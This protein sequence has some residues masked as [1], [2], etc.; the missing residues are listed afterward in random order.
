[1]NDNTELI[2][3]IFLKKTIFEKK[4]LN[5]LSEKDRFE[6]ID[7]LS[8]SLVYDTLKEHLNFIYIKNISD[9]TLQHIPNIIFKVLANE[10]ISYATELL[11]LSRVEALEYLQTAN[12]VKYIHT[13]A[14]SYYLYCRN[15]IYEK[16]ADTFI[17]LLALLN[18]KSERVIFVNEVINSKLMANKTVLRIN[19]FNQLY[20]KIKFA[21]N[22]KNTEISSIQMK[23]TDSREMLKNL[24]QDE[25]IKE[26]KALHRYIK[27]EK[28]TNKLG[29]ENFDESLKRVKRS[30]INSLKNGIYES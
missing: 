18:L 17:E 20:K 11:S 23:I 30:I 7:I 25:E 28:E 5:V 16:I 13:L 26:R 2:D 15:S 1:L 27:I 10:W 4:V 14:Q 22:K 3:E 6:I 29:L 12:N 24:K 8:T 21:K 9:F 19:D